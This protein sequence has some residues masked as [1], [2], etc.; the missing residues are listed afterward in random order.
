MKLF[1]TDYV[2][3]GA[4]F[5]AFFISAFNYWIGI[6]LVLFLFMMLN[7]IST[8]SWVVLLFITTINFYSTQERTRIVRE[9][10]KHPR[11]N[12][13]PDISNGILEWMFVMPSILDVEDLITRCEVHANK[14]CGN[15][16]GELEV[17]YLAQ[18]LVFIKKFKGNTF[19]K[20]N[21]SGNLKDK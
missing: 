8:F 15:A 3:I 18:V 14:D 9:I 17:W 21:A 2:H 20:V 13:S 19:A 11:V 12:V 1:I 5:C 10:V 7:M 16:K 4:S 6:N